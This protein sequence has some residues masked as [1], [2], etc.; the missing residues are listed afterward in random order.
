LFQ[1]VLSACSSYFEKLFSTFDERNQIVI[2]KDTPFR[3][4][5]SLMEFMY[6]GEARVAQQRLASLLATAENL[7]VSIP[8]CQ[9][10]IL[11]VVMRH[12][13]LTQPN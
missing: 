10:V 3:D 5:L 7:K 6:R 1:V 11:I 12:E 4:V 8:N 13:Q 9:I 2:L